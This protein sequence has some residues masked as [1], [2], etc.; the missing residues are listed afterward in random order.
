MFKKNGKRE[1]ER[2][3]FVHGNKWAIFC[4]VYVICYK[5]DEIVVNCCALM[6]SRFFFAFPFVYS[7]F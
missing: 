7:L 2:D 3:V 6:K 4:A 5:K 1:K